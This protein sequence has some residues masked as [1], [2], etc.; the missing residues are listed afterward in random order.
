MKHNSVSLHR[1]RLFNYLLYFILLEIKLVHI[2]IFFIVK[3]I[4]HA[5]KVF[6]S[7]GN[8][9]SIKNLFGNAINV[10]KVKHTYSDF[11]TIITDKLRI[12]HKMV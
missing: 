5:I 3:T 2:L 10:T 12:K 6:W 1:A 4:R 7:R 11:I 9:D 8:M